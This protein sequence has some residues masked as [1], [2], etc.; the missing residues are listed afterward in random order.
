MPYLSLFVFVCISIGLS[1]V[2]GLAPFFLAKRTPTKEKEAMYE[3]GFSPIKPPSAKF[4]M[5]F[6]LVAILFII[7]DL[8]IAFIFPWAIS[9]A[10]MDNFGFIS[11]MVF[12]AVLSI[13]FVYEVG[14]GALSWE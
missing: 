7:F 9:F 11:M 13:G 1:I 8:E 3:C 2:L 5:R 12:L 6:Y 14:K 4:S 10:K